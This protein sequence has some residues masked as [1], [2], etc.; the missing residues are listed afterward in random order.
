MVIYD[1]YVKIIQIENTTVRVRALSQFNT[2]IKHSNMVEN[3][4]ILNNSTF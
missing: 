4:C 1:I 3:S 2:P